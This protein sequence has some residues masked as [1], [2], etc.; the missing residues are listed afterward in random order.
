[1]FDLR[2][3]PS[4]ESLPG[5]FINLC[6]DEEEIPMC[7]LPAGKVTLTE[8]QRRELK[9]AAYRDYYARER[10]HINARRAAK[11]KGKPKQTPE[12]RAA[13]KALYW[14]TNRERINA[15]RRKVK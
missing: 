14:A 11:R 12:E 4:L 5:R 3:T 10:K 15:R 13:V 9:N 6:W 2:T 8:E 1:M 7:A